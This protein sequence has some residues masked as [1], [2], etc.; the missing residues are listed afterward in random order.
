V[1]LVVGLMEPVKRYPDAAPAQQFARHLAAR[2]IGNFVILS[3]S[4]DSP[5]KELGDAVGGAIREYSS[6]Q[7]ITQ[8]PQALADSQRYHD[9]AYLD[10]CGVQTGAGWGRKPLGAD[11]AARNAVEC[12]LALYNHRPRKPVMNLEAR[13]DSDFNQNQMPR[14]P[15][16]CGYWSLLSGCA[17][18]TYGCAGI[19]NWGL[20]TTHDDPQASLWD[21]RTGVD[22][23]SSIDMKHLAEFFAGVDWWRLEPHH[24]LILNQSDDWTKRLVL[25]KSGNGDL[26][27]AYLPDNPTITVEMSAFTGPVTWRWF[28]PE[29]G[30]SQAGQGEAGNRGQKTFERPPGWGDALLVLRGPKS[31]GTTP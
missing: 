20:K 26:A 11:I 17:G 28:N 10:F 4:F 5:Y 12:C 15:R 25:A 27:V 31:K 30:Q 6:G 24:E 22:R 23:P 3:P 21:W 19:W 14:L 18:Y 16:S 13:Y 8:H 29:T 1:V 7:L 2:L 9:Q